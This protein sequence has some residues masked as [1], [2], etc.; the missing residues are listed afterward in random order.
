MQISKKRIEIINENTESAIRIFDEN[1]EKRAGLVYDKGFLKWNNETCNASHIFVG[2]KTA[3]A[4]LG[5]S[6]FPI[7]RKSHNS[8]GPVLEETPKLRLSY[9]KE[10]KPGPELSLE[11]NEGKFPLLTMEKNTGSIKDEKAL[12]GSRSIREE[13]ISVGFDSSEM[14]S[15][16]FFD[17]SENLRTILGSAELVKKSGT[18]IKTPLSSIVLFNEKGNVI[19]R[20]PTE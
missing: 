11:I 3:Y 8:N 2:G 10:D 4:S 16:K 7:L 17:K 18:E 9:N 20:A 1:E 13:K 12:G 5:V 14:P 19:W 15:I 6:Y